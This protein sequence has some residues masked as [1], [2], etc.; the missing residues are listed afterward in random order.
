[1]LRVD[2]ECEQSNYPAEQ[3]AGCFGLHCVARP[4]SSTKTSTGSNPDG[5]N[6]RKLLVLLVA[7]VAELADALDS[8][9]SP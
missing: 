2:D 7:R 3:L 5:I 8:G 6:V 4:D 1:M 9:S